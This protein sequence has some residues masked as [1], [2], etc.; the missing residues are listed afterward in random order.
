MKT[1]RILLSILMLLPFAS[2]SNV[3]AFPFEKPIKTVISA[4]SVVKQEKAAEIARLAAEKAAQVA[5]EKAAQVAAEKA[6]QVAAQVAA[7]L[8]ARP[9]YTKACDAVTGFEY[10]QF[11]ADNGGRYVADSRIGMGVG[12]YYSKAISGAGHYSSKG[13]ELAKENPK[14]TAAIVTAVVVAAG[15]GAYFKFRT[16]KTEAQELEARLEAEKKDIARAEGSA[17]AQ[18]QKAVRKN[19]GT[20]VE[21]I[22]MLS[23]EAGRLAG[24]I[25]RC[26]NSIDGMT[27]TSRSLP[28]AIKS[29]GRAKEAFLAL[30]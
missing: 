8:A 26:T 1:S 30:S 15:V 11:V 24:K 6:A 9:W 10:G 7:E 2:N 29:L 13:V 4:F 20:L 23:S 16:P 12:H 19:D 25:V 27:E 18:A 22:P 5:A 21:F 28:I 14:T 3:V 17:L